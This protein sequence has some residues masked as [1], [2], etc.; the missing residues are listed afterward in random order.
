MLVKSTKFFLVHP[1]R[2]QHT[3]LQLHPVVIELRPT[4][5]LFF[6]ALRPIY[7][8]PFG[9]SSMALMLS[10]IS[11]PNCVRAGQPWPL[12]P[13][14][15][16]IHIAP[17]VRRNAANFVGT[18]AVEDKTTLEIPWTTRHIGNRRCQETPVDNSAV[19]ASAPDSQQLSGDGL[20]RLVINTPNIYPDTTDFGVTVSHI[21]SASLRSLV[22]AVRR[23]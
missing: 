23:N 14:H 19:A 16:P 13:A 1:G 22:R 10:P 7:T 18:F 3:P 17:A 12:P 6:P 2:K 4:T 20:Q 5:R 15:S 11:A 21:F 8:L 9:F